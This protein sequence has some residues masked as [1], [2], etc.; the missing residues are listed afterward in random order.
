M[1]S[2]GFVKTAG[3]YQFPGIDLDKV[4]EMLEK[5]KN[6]KDKDEVV[7]KKAPAKMIFEPISTSGIM[8]ITFTHKMIVPKKFD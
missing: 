7:E 6:N 5:K 8:K 1:A 2:K 4:N 3:G